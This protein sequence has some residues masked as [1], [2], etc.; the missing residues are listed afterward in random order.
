MR[1][2]A[3]IL[4]T[5]ISLL[6][7]QP[8]ITNMISLVKQSTEHCGTNCCNK[9]QKEEN[10]PKNNCDQNNCNPCQACGNC[11]C[12]YYTE[13]SFSIIKIPATISYNH[14]VNEA[15]ISNFSN[16]CFHPPERA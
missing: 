8:V 1:H 16:D 2:L 13:S 7:F 14:V 4:A 6:A 5:Y 11:C 10:A 9:A 3:F 15:A 12:Y